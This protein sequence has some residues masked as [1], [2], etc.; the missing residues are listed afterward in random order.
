MNCIKSERQQEF[1]VIHLPQN[2]GVTKMGKGR[3][4]GSGVR[5]GFW[6][7]N[8]FTNLTPYHPYYSQV[9]KILKEHAGRLEREDDIFYYEYPAVSGFVQ[10]LT[11]PNI[12][13]YM[14][15]LPPSFQTD[16]RGI[17]LC[18]GAKKQLNYSSTVYGCYDNLSRSIF[19]F[20]F[21]ERLCFYYK[22][23]PKPSECREYERHGAHWK[24]ENGY[25]KLDF[26][27]E[28][29]RSFY[30]RDVLV[31]ELGHHVDN[32]SS[33]TG[34]NS[35]Q[36]ERF[37][38]WFAMAFGINKSGNNLTEFSKMLQELIKLGQ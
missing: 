19:L 20:P 12:Q 2:F 23:K 26:T 5:N 36:K 38:E 30:L 35:N 31:H 10:L 21:P 33:L 17:F 14:S 1:C 27:M 37:A 8:K 34:E 9:D 22:A 18:P 7:E 29:L 32:I 13:K 25:W 3:A 15:Y 28:S 24:Q 11:I 16:L 6:S 4:R